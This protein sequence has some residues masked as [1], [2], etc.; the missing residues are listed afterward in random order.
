MFDSLFIDKTTFEEKEREGKF[1]L[2]YVKWSKKEGKYIDLEND[3]KKGLEVILLN[4]STKRKE[5]LEF[6]KSTIEKW[7]I[8]G[9]L[10]LVDL[11][12]E[13]FNS[14]FIF[15]YGRNLENDDKNK[16]LFSLSVLIKGDKNKGYLFFNIAYPKSQISGEK[17]TDGIIG[18]AGSNTRNSMILYAFNELNCTKVL[19]EVVS[20]KALASLLDLG[21]K[22]FR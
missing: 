16:K 8:P 11:K 13:H 9:V 19:T 18:A 21:F 7:G 6:V 3:E 10:A 22:K 20:D 14:N 5:I 4:N 17:R 15:L 2:C 1:K 12:E